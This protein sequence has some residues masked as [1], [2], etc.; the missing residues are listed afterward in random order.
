MSIIRLINKF[1]LIYFFFNI[2][3]KLGFI[4][5]LPPELVKAFK[6]TLDVAKSADLILNVSSFG[7]DYLA[8]HDITDGFLNE[9]GATEN[10][11]I[12]INKCDL[13]NFEGI[14][15]LNALEISAK[16]GQGIDELLHKIY[17]NLFN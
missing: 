13:K 17:D 6:S 1:G 9:L 3:K 5:E 4:K 14:N 10:R 8:E 12:V 15:L 16:T 2:Q 11:I 7:D